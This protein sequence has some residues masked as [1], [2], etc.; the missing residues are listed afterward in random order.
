MHEQVFISR[1]KD[2]AAAELEGIFAQ[3]VLFMSGRLGALAGLHVVAAQKMEQGSILQFNGFV[4]FAL[5]VDQQREIDAG[6]LAEELGVAHVTQS[7]GGQARTFLAELLFMRAQ[8]RDVFAAENSTI[9]AQED[10]HGRPVGPQRSQAES[11]TGN[12][13][14]RNAGQLAA[15]RFSHAGHSLSRKRLC[16]ADNISSFEVL[17]RTFAI[18][19]HL[20]ERFVV[21]LL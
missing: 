19:A 17:P 5:L 21:R 6:F 11:I 10:H 15:E 20:C 3:F 13:G 16:Q 18:L 9:V 7:D 2:E 14:K 12:I 8:L 1:S 4:G